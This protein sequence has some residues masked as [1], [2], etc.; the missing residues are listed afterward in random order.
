M[1]DAGI[2]VRLSTPT[3]TVLL[4]VS[5]HAFEGRLATRKSGHYAWIA[6]GTGGGQGCG[7]PSYSL[8]E[9]YDPHNSD[10]DDVGAMAL[11]AVTLPR[12]LYC[13][14]CWVDRPESTPSSRCS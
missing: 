2:D 14:R 4:H 7:V 9:G 1:A 6:N 13:R 3:D 12:L 10:F 5:D 11:T 8:P